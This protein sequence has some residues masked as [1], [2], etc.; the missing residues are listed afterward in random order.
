MTVR[1]WKGWWVA[2]VGLGLLLVGLGVLLVRAG[3]EDADRWASV[4]GVLLNIAGL[5]VAVYSAVW[6]RRA[7]A[8]PA[9]PAA[10]GGQV[11]N[12]IRGG[13][14]AGPVVQAR[15]VERASAS[16]S[17]ALAAAPDAAPAVGPARPGAVSN[18]IE[19]GQFHGPVLQGRDMRGAFLPASRHADTQSGQENP[20]G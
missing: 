9:P 15:D 14:F 16:P 5:S 6:T 3:L 8:A 17:E 12:T 7:V 19:D 18:L 13:R 2:G 10:T 11:D 1:G 4:F 20:A